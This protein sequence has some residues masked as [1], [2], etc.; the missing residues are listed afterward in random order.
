MNTK[1]TAPASAA[2][3]GRAWTARLMAGLERRPWLLPLASFVVGWAGY[4]LIERGPALARW[5]ALLALLS[6]PWMLLDHLFGRWLQRASKGRLSPRLT[7]FV[8]QSVQQEM[9]FFALPFVL[10][11]LRMSLEHVLFG[12]LLA[13]AALFSTL[14]PLYHRWAGR[15]GSGLG[16]A[17]Q[18]YCTFITALV[19]LPL[20]LHLPVERAV[21]VAVLIALLALAAGLPRLFW[22]GA[23][24]SPRELLPVAAIA[25][26][27]LLGLPLRAWIPPAGLKLTEARISQSIQALEPGPERRQLSSAEL[28][29]G[30]VAYVAVHA[31][32]GLSQP[33]RFDWYLD[34]RRL[35]SIPARIEGAPGR[36][37][38]TYTRKQHFPVLAQ[39]HW[40]VDLRTPGDQLIGRLYFEVL[41]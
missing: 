33:L 13:A 7:A 21:P 25:V 17:F 31:P 2:G 5:V 22:R 9:L 26:L 12:L 38:R 8:T 36:G 28:S 1:T 16:I 35:D 29:Q 3:T 4:L 27:L 34:G 18:A 37:W 6:W 10:G 23:G 20:A 19:V 11:A 39:G 40:R 14:D 15:G 32:A 41:P 24:R 30:V